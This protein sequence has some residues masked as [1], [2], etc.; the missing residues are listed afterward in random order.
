MAILARVV[1]DS[2][3]ESGDRITTFEVTFNRYIL[4][5]FNTHR[6]LSRNSASSRAI[7]SWKIIDAVLHDPA[8]PVSWGANQS[9][10]QARQELS[11]WRRWAA[12]GL[13][14]AARYPALAMAW[15]MGKVGLHKQVTNRLL[16]PWMWHTAIVTATELDNFFGQRAHPDA[17][18]EFQA[19]AYAMRSVR[20]GSVPQ[21]RRRGEWHLPLLT[22]AE[23]DL[24]H[25][26]PL[27]LETY[28]KVSAARC[29]RVSYTRHNDARDLE[30]DVELYEKLRASKRDGLPHWSPLEHPAR[31]E[32]GCGFVGNF[33]GWVQARKLHRGES[34]RVDDV[35]S[36]W[37]ED[38]GPKRIAEAN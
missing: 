38:S 9:G 26:D 14:R 12:R 28:V 21:L 10:M 2:I 5:E 7:P 17:Q 16:E 1:L 13:W 11:G 25:S 32:P 18:P 36:D 37:T 22:P 8:E 23:I 24:A 27:W 29:A 34:G 30:L 33:R 4:A 19:L 3:N 31:A 35:G 20:L 15:L 6:M